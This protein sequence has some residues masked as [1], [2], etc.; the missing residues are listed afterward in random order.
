MT[1]RAQMMEYLAQNLEP[2]IAW[3]PEP[4]VQPEPEPDPAALMGSLLAMPS[5][6]KMSKSSSKKKPMIRVCHCRDI[7]CPIGPFI[8]IEA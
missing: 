8:E 7:R 3:E 1:N 6:I 2:Q 4:V 5:R